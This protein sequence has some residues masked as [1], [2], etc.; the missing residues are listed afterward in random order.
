MTK[1]SIP[2]EKSEKQRDK[3]QNASENFEYT[4]IADR[5]RT[6]SWSNDNHETGVLKELT[7]FQPSY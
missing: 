2:T 4:P 5:L 1:A 6:V 7:G 3:T